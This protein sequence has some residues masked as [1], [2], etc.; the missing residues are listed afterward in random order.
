MK[1]FALITALLLAPGL[2]AAQAPQGDAYR[3]MRDVAYRGATG[4]PYTDS[5]C[6][7]DISYPQGATGC[8]VIVWFH[9]GGLTGGHR[10]IPAALQGQG[11]AV[12]GVGYRFSPRVRVADCIDD[13]AAAVAWVY[14][15]IGE[16]GGS[17]SKIYLAGHSAGAYLVSM[18]G[19]DRQYLARHGVA[20]DSMAALIPYSGNAVTHLACRA[21]RGIP[22][23]QP[24]V[25]SMAPLY[26]VRRDTP[27]ILILSGDRAMEMYGRYEENA[28]L[29]RMFQVVG[30]PGVQLRE[31]DGFDHGTMVGP[32]HFL[33]LR[34]IR[35]R[36]NIR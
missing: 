17:P 4:D 6:R 32:G 30:N 29:W 35:E 1:R 24:V 34:F 2:L 11:I 18:L 3:V 21:E 5:M 27:P 10:E 22:P 36:E 7:L 28:Y 23:T 16:L 12:A 20:A 9:G 31:L 26:H 14:R 25:D 8:P 15:H 33:A 13:A 19:L